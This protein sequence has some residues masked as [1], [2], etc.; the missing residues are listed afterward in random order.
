M[1]YQGLYRII[2][3]LS[4]LCLWVSTRISEDWENGLGLVL[5][6]S[7]GVIHGANDVR[8][9]LNKSERSTKRILSFILKYLVV[10][11]LGTVGFFLLPQITLGLFILVS[12][13]H[14]GQEHFE[15]YQLP[16]SWKNNLF[17]AAYGLLI[18]LMLFKINSSQS[19]N[20]INEI[21]SMN[22]TEQ[23]LY[24][25]LLATCVILVATGA[26]QLRGL[27]LKTIAKELLYLAVI[28]IIFN[29]SSL[30]WG[31]AIYFVLWHSIPSMYTQITFLYGDSNQSHVWSY[32]KYSSLYWI[33]SLIFLGVLYFFLQE[34]TQFL[35]TIIVAFLGGIT[36]PHVFV[37]DKMIKKA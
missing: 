8:I 28:F 20:V 30:L 23:Q 11:F 4:F 33:A 22:I 29:T 1:S 17:V 5:I 2:L 36:F 12:G 35:L 14:F 21:V 15:K 19:L 10:V 32:I 25:A 16:A 24:Y 9:H 3:I 31:F 13:Y 7:I 27:P 6:L 18:L 34:R 26:Y 37:M